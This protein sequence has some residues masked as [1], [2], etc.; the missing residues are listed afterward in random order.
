M[1]AELRDVRGRRVRAQLKST[2][3]VPWAPDRALGRLRQL[4]RRVVLVSDRRG[5]TPRPLGPIA[6]VVVTE[7]A[8]IP[9]LEKGR[10]DVIIPGTA[11]LLETMDLFNFTALTVSDAG[12][13]EGVLLRNCG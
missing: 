2:I 3:R 12:L 6:V 8:G 11:I 10:E 7:R 9:G 13:L 1:E 4:V 5:R